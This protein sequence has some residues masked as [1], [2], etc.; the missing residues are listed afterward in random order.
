MT[1]LLDKRF[2]PMFWTQFSGAFND[3]FFKNALGILVVYSGATAF[4]LS[5]EQFV[6]LTAAVFMLPYFLF[7]A[8]A[9]QLADKIEK[10]RLVRGIKLAEIGIMGLA[11]VGF[12]LENNEL[13]VLVLFLMGSQSAVFGPVKYGILPQ[14]L[15]KR[16]LTG[17]NA[18]VELATYLAILGGTIAG[19]LLV[20]WEY[21]GARIG[22]WLVCAGV[23]GLAVIGWGLST[24]IIE[25]P[26]TDPG[27]TVQWNPVTPTWQI[28]RLTWRDRDIFQAVLGITWFW[29]FGTAFLSL[30]PSYAKD[31]LGG[32]ESVATLFLAAF[33]CGIALGSVLCERLS[34]HRLEL[35]L[36]PIGAVGLSLFCALLSLIG[37]PWVNDGSALMHVGVF[38]TRPMGLAIFFLLIAI[39]VSG[40]LFIV[41]LYTFIQLRS[42]PSETSRVIAGNNIINAFFMVAMSGALI[43]MQGRGM[44][45][46]T[47]FGVLAIANALASLVVFSK[48]PEF[49][50]R[51][52]A[53]FLSNLFYRIDVEGL[54]KVPSEGPV[55]VVANHITFVDWLIVLGVVKRPIHF[56]M[57]VSFAHLPIVRWVSGQ[58]W[59]IPIASPKRDEVTYEQAFVSIRRKLRQGWVVGIFPEG[60]LTG[61]GEMDVFRRGGLTK[62]LER[63]PVPV[64]PIALNGLWGS[65]TSRKAGNALSTFP[66]GF[67]SELRVT[68]G[69]PVPPEQA[70]P[71]HLEALVRTM[72][73]QFPEKK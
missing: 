51:F 67:R 44:D 27:L 42:N 53:W 46:P 50:L 37:T 65:W 57:D 59:V 12:L 63:D 69:D 33:S 29:S 23:V 25:A 28:L 64:V 22:V 16:D 56:V 61:D 30:F 72:W 73:E 38:L 6:P 54:E 49:G 18:L 26:P 40:G 45:A 58:E 17:G 70:T 71:E 15:D 62:I 10:A 3:N 41:P 39:A 7:S 60:K 5:S 8:T 13:L 68:I 24:R 36:V 19:G 66:R 1:L 31:V 4:G 48:V 21:N 43:W 52:C 14:L 9:G 11:V 34:R 35:G 2:W 47:I 32:G 55:L 20:T